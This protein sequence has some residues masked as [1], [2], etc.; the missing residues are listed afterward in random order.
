MPITSVRLKNF[1]CF[2]DSGTI[3][4]K[5]LTIIFGRN[6]TGKSSILYSL[7]L[8][9][10]SLDSPAYGERLNMR[11][12]LYQAGAFADMVH[13]HRSK[14]SI[15]MT[16]GVTCPPPDLSGDIELEF[17]SDEPQAPRLERLRVGS[18]KGAD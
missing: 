17:S 1:R 4:V 3:P 16:F 8:L 10:Q 2:A 9:R 14:E 5:P 6:N 11:G 12:P 13:Q 15:T 18:L 7:F